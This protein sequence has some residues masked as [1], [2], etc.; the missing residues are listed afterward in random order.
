MSA[1]SAGYHTP[2]ISSHFIYKSS[3]NNAAPLQSHYNNTQSINVQPS[4]AS[5]N[6]TTSE[7]HRLYVMVLA[8]ILM[9][10]C[11]SGLMSSTAV[12]SIIYLSMCIVCLIGFVGTLSGSKQ[13]MIIFLC[14]LIIL[15]IWESVFSILACIDGESYMNFD[16][17]M[18]CGMAVGIR[19][20]KQCIDMSDCNKLLSRSGSRRNTMDSYILPL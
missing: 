4:N 3:V 13:C 9:L 15:L 11:T 18:M 19:E 16:T 5:S 8:S 6:N 12:H 2:V 1:Q 7:L 10:L 20:T 17:V 14:L